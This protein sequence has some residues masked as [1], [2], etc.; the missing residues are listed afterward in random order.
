[1]SEEK[2]TRKEEMA[3]RTVVRA[4]DLDPRFK[5]EIRKVPGAEKITLCFQCGTCTAGC[6]VARFSDTYRPRRI[7]RMTQL[8]LKG[9]LLPS[10]FIWLCTSCFTCVDHCPQD[11][12]VAGIVRTLQN[13]A[14]EEGYVPLVYKELASNITRTGLAYRIPEL[15]LKRRERVGLP[16]LPKA[17]IK[18]VDKLTEVTGLLK[19]VQTRGG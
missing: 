3:P 12:D 9:R 11:V 5:Y 17:N 7:L 8:G 2:E 10:D 15:R 4:T 1:M 14:V 13:L 19:L 18:V 6:P 16:P